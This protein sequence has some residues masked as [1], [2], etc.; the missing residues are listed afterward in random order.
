MHWWSWRCRCRRLQ[1]SPLPA[2]F[3]AT[4]AAR[5]CRS[6]PAEAGD[7]REVA[8]CFSGSALDTEYTVGGVSRH[9]RI[10]YLA[11]D[12]RGEHRENAKPVR[13]IWEGRVG[14]RRGAHRS[15]HHAVRRRAGVRRVLRGRHAG[16]RDQVR[17]R[18]PER[19]AD[20]HA[21]P[22]RHG[23]ADRGDARSMPRCVRAMASSTR[24]RSARPWHASRSASRH[25]SYCRPFRSSASR[26]PGLSH[27]PRAADR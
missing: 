21:E 2:R 13:S 18:C 26:A 15:R 3:R 4:K 23:R 27:E 7:D 5:S 9:D 12:D 8:R 16:V 11:R 25:P 19:C 22:A 10:L 17:I 6:W 20:D 24:S 14:I 1:S